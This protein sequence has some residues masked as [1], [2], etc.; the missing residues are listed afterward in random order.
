MRKSVAAWL[1]MFCW[2][3]AGSCAAGTIAIIPR[4]QQMTPGAGSYRLDG[5]ARISAPEG[6]RARQIAGFLRTAIRQRTGI[7]V[8]LG[9]SVHGIVLRHDPSVRG[10]EAYRLVVTPQQVMISAS[11]DKGLFWGVQTLRQLVPLGRASAAEIPA[12]SITDAPRYAWRGVMLDVARHFYPVGFIEKQLDLLSYYK[13][14]VF[15]WHLT[16]DQ[17]WR[18]QIKRYPRLTRIGAWRT[19]ADGSRYGGFYTQAQ[20]RA[21][22]AYA[23]SRN[24]MVVPEIEMPGHSTAAIAAYPELSCSGKPV[25]VPTTWGV[26]KDID[27]VGKPA[28][29]AFLQHVLDEVM[30]LFPAPYV[31][32]GGDEVPKD[33]WIDCASCQALMRAQGMT[34]VEQLQSWFI[35][36]IQRYLTGKGKTLI[37]W[38]E[39]LEG[40]AN[41]N[42]IIEIWRG[43]DEE[44][45]ALRNG[46]RVIVAGPFYLDTPL[47]RLTTQDVYRTDIARDATSATASAQQANDAVF[48]AHRAQIL[49]AEAP[50]WGERANPFNAESKL[51]PR[52]L[53]LAE[54]LWS[55]GTQS[56]AA[57][58]DFQ[59]RLRAQ[60]AWLDAQHVAYGPEDRN[61]MVYSVTVNARHDGWQ[62]HAQRGFDD[63]HIHYTTDGSTPALRSPAFDD[64]LNAAHAGTLLVVPFRK[65]LRYDNPDRFT[66]LDNLALGKPLTFA[67]PP[68]PKYAPGDVLVD[69]QLGSNDFNDGRWAA[70]H[71]TDLDA[72]IGLQKVTTIH[73]IS[74]GFLQAIGSRIA[75]PRQVTILASTDGKHWTT[76]QVAQP[77]A[78]LTDTR[79]VQLRIKFNATR[80]L[81]ARYVRVAAKRYTVLPTGF[82]G[83]GQELWLFADEILLR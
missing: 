79:P 44:A 65:G 76:L 27:C 29:F 67:Q 2:L 72:T 23:R 45:K 62:L 5:Q 41:K 52:T 42:A 26:F 9:P 10:E 13:I 50:L 56:P 70:W 73:S 83:G 66:L 71:N 6:A 15:H 47:N 43:S 60:V 80:P 8:R 19:E 57:L 31:H 55:G 58:A 21:V 54:N 74:I 24:I 81:K 33:D 40:G 59:Q 46:N 14:N 38:D 37:G 3:I 11:T 64:V 30:A 69:G 36:R 1:L 35:Q 20:I 22:V 12:V 49:G 78:D 7:A 48:A 4:P 18:I 28:T 53:A 63:L 25:T 39:I 82:P 34:S 51:Y 32:I 61:V 75:P 16:D 77:K 68:S 17:G